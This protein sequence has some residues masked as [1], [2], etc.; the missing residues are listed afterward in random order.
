VNLIYFVLC[1]YGLTQVL[2]YA[3]ILNS[4]RPSEGK[5]GEMFRCPMCM[6]F[7]VGVILWLLNGWTELFSFDRSL[8]TGFLLGCLSSGTSYIF[9]MLFG[10][11]GIKLEHKGIN[12]RNKTYHRRLK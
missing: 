9:N 5:L 10:D 11:D 7:W 4:V 6:G 3:T 2:V 1:S 8:I 12:F